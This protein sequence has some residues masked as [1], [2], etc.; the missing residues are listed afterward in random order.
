M[1]PQARAVVQGGPG[2][3][4]LSGPRALVQGGPGAMLLSGPSGQGSGSRRESLHGWVHCFCFYLL[5][6]A[7]FSKVLS[8][9]P[10]A[11]PS[12][13]FSCLRLKQLIFKDKKTY[14]SG[15]LRGMV[16]SSF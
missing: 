14:G 15:T 9:W 2:T 13:T 12:G 11:G 5:V 16:G 1:A 8:L 3:M 7:V 4:L 10:S 6:S